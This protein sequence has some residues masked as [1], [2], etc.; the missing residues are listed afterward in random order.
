[1]HCSR[2]ENYFPLFSILNVPP[3]YSCFQQIL[4]ITG[5]K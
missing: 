4:F 1:L 3:V 2:E 5:L